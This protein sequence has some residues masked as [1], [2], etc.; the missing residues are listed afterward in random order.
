M[1]LA[2]AGSRALGCR[3]PVFLVLLA[4][5]SCGGQEI[6]ESQKGSVSAQRRVSAAEQLAGDWKLSLWL[7]S[8]GIVM[9]TV[10]LQE[11]GHGQY[12]VTATGLRR[13]GALRVTAWDGEWLE[14]TAAGFRRRMRA[15]I[16]GNI[17]YIEL[18]AVG[19]VKLIRTSPQ[20]GPVHFS[21][22]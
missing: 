3:L 9:A 6:T 5:L 8:H 1:P 17:L 14:G 2:D 20:G 4:V 21:G 11:T 18:P 10:H 13:S 22:S 19:T 7:P 15:T 12:L 16:E